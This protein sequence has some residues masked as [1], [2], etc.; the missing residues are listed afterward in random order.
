MSSGERTFGCHVCS[1]FSQKQRATFHSTLWT[2]RKVPVSRD[3]LTSIL[4]RFWLL[5]TSVI[6]FVIIAK[7]KMSPSSVAVEPQKLQPPQAS[8]HN[9]FLF[10]LP[11]FHFISCSLID[12][13]CDDGAVRESEGWSEEESMFL[14]VEGSCGRAV[15]KK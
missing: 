3:A 7:S 5:L 15:M 12:S 13:L 4:T 2:R 14:D 6:L 9:P 10:S 8:R 1:C 11:P